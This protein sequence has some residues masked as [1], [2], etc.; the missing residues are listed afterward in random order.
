MAQ[1][2][3]NLWFVFYKFMNIIC[4]TE[5]KGCLFSIICNKVSPRAKSLLNQHYKKYQF[6]CLCVELIS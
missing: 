4:E 2:N 3:N 1:S 5:T 6:T